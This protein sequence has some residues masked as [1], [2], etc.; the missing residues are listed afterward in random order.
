MDS[1]KFE[2]WLSYKSYQLHDLWC[3]SEDN[4]RPTVLEDRLSLQRCACMV[5][6]SPRY[7]FTYLWR[8]STSL[9]RSVLSF[10]PGLD[11]R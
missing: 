2:D 9:S 1:L 6:Q 8:F 10:S 5:T 3:H 11:F 7:L 4:S